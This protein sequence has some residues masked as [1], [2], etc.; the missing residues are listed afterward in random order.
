MIFIDLR[1][2]FMF[3]SISTDPLSLICCLHMGAMFICQR[4]TGVVGPDDVGCY[5]NNN[6]NTLLNTP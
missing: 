5:N 3:S 1:D 6:N 4:S 2:R